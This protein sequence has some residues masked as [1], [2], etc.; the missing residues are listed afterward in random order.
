MFEFKEEKRSKFCG[1][2]VGII[3]TE[4]GEFETPLYVFAGTDAEIRTL[5]KKSLKEVKALVANTYHL[6][7]RTNKIKEMEKS[8]GL[9]KY[10]NF[11]ATSK[12]EAFTNVIPVSE[13][14]VSETETLV[15]HDTYIKHKKENIVDVYETE[16][17]FIEFKPHKNL[18]KRKD[19]ILL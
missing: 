1:A 18:I 9:H 19:A 13:V 17:T 3:K 5:D 12:K 14:L 6:G 15:G 7:V 10:M 4:Y 2:R 11:K 8:G 16:Q